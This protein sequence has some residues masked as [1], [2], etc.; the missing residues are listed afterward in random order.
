MLKNRKNFFPI[1]CFFFI[2]FSLPYL[3]CQL[4]SVKQYI[5]IEQ[6]TEL[7]ERI[8]KAL[9][10][11]KGENK[12]KALFLYQ[13]GL[14]KVHAFSIPF[15][16]L[17]LEY[18]LNLEK[19]ILYY[20]E[21]KDILLA[22]EH[23]YIPE[24]YQKYHPLII[25]PFEL[26]HY[27][28]V[29]QKNG[30]AGL[31]HSANE[32]FSI[33]LYTGAGEYIRSRLSKIFLSSSDPQT[34][35]LLAQAQK[36]YKEAL[37]KADTQA[38][39]YLIENFPLD[40]FGEEAFLALGDIYFS[41][42]KIEEALGVWKRLQSLKKPQNDSALHKRIALA[43]F[44]YQDRETYSSLQHYTQGDARFSQLEKAFVP[45]PKTPFAWL[46]YKGNY[47]H[48]HVMDGKDL[49]KGKRKIIPIRLPFHF[50]RDY[51]KC[52]PDPLVWNNRLY[53]YLPSGVFC[54]SM[55]TASLLWHFIFPESRKEEKEEYPAIYTSSIH[56]G[57]LYLVSPQNRPAN[58]IYC[59]DA[60][61]GAQL[62]HWPKEPNGNIS[63]QQAPVIH[64]N[65]LFVSAKI[66]TGQVNVELFCL[67][68]SSSPTLLWQRFL[69][70]IL[71]SE[72]EKKN[73]QTRA[74]G[75]SL[76][77]GLVYC[78]S[79]LGVMAAVDSHNGEI[80][81][82]A[83]YHEHFPQDYRLKVDETK[84]TIL[85]TPPIIRNG[86]VHVMPLDTSHL[87]VYNA[88]S[89]NLIKS[90]PESQLE[91]NLKNLLG[92]NEEG[93]VFLNT[94]YEV[95]CLASHG[96]K[97]ILWTATL[98]SLIV[99]TGFVTNS[100]IYVFTED[101]SLYQIHA[102][103]GKLYKI[104]SRLLEKSLPGFCVSMFMWEQD[105]KYNILFS[106]RDVFLWQID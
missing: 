33:G 53:Y 14:E 93:N 88:I 96:P 57:R 60:S 36:I 85:G 22:Q 83:K 24:I 3:D 21:A 1:V 68:I 23:Q 97:E 66:L 101:Q 99:G 58:R 31:Y 72:L 39:R 46:S 95:L 20:L 27:A 42:G 64:E 55:D 78:C 106:G 89:G 67:D 18:I 75:V 32:K 62:W 52:Y 34:A 102:K 44:F 29:Y 98:P 94:E 82:I 10:Q 2:Y 43:S 90:F 51:E 35:L 73:K 8:D 28:A 11:E 41:Q 9:V 87:L 91:S 15:S 40:S 104:T 17:E 47:A 76:C 26:K 86:K 103:T 7:R 61:T 16:L 25:S 70:S 45:S 49:R 74:S 13:K 84:N 81:W 80:R 4:S 100:W 50:Y 71:S 92:V 69:G 59:F 19:A 38:L 77:Y 5:Y 37:H 65:R 54:F 79:N 12:E 30:L 63:F 56:E 48:N 6:D 105:R